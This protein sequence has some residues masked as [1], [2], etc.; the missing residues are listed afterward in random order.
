MPHLVYFL[1]NAMA[2]KNQLVQKF[3]F[4][5][6]SQ[7]KSLFPLPCENQVCQMRH[8]K[9]SRSWER[10]IVDQI[11]ILP[12]GPPVYYTVLSAVARAGI[13]ERREIQRSM[14]AKLSP[15]MVRLVPDSPSSLSIHAEPLE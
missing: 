6:Y 8:P 13:R 15:K 3:F 4:L 2:F 9:G 10:I 12:A 7:R 1:L 14:M 11:L 5:L